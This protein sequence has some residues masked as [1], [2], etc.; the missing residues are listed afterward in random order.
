MSALLAG[1]AGMTTIRE[2]VRNARQRRNEALRMH[3]AGMSWPE[4]GAHFGVTAARASQ[5]AARATRTVKPRVEWAG[6][7]A[8]YVESRAQ[9]VRDV[10]DATLARLGATT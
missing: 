9:A 10:A 2:R 6:T 3:E 1:G 4:V 7:I 5:L 8:S